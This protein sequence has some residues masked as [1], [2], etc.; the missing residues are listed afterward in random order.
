VC[1]VYTG[2]W[3]SLYIVPLNSPFDLYISVV[4]IYEGY[5]FNPKEWFSIFDTGQVQAYIY[6]NTS[7]LNIIVHELIFLT[8]LPAKYWVKA[9]SCATY[10]LWK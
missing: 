4:K 2:I 6:I 5:I 10:R 3:S 1:N 9:V 7:K 8:S